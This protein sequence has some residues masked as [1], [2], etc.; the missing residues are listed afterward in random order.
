MQV[1]DQITAVVVARR[2]GGMQ[3]DGALSVN[4]QPRCSHCGEERLVEK[5]SKPIWASAGASLYFCSA[6]DKTFLW[7]VKTPSA[8][9]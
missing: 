1:F 9:I 4:D 8:L 3:F 6:C 2:R 7:W 5:V